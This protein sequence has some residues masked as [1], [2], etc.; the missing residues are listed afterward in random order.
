MHSFLLRFYKICTVFEPIS[1]WTVVETLC[2]YLISISIELRALRVDSMT[3]Q[4]TIFIW[5]C[6]IVLTEVKNGEGKL[7][8]IW[9]CAI[10][11]V[12]MECWPMIKI[13]THIIESKRILIADLV[14][15]VSISKVI[16]IMRN[17]LEIKKISI[18][19]RI[20]DRNQHSSS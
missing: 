13:K 20:M 2:P 11:S 7:L 1:P 16:V 18:T 6:K 9:Y 5:M 4:R 17:M 3:S 15:S 12:V 14:I 19:S 8:A 10:L